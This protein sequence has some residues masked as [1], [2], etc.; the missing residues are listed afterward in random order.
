MDSETESD[1]RW[2][3]SVFFLCLSHIAPSSTVMRILLLSNNNMRR[4]LSSSSS[5]ITLVTVTLCRVHKRQKSKRRC[6]SGLLA[7]TVL[8][9]ITLSCGQ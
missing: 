6:V 2:K 5:L 8:E 3:I 1:E 9:V 7:K 4:L